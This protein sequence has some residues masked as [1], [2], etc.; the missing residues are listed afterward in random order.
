MGGQSRRGHDQPGHR[1]V[2][3]VRRRFHFIRIRRDDR[4]HLVDREAHQF[5]IELG[6]DVIATAE[7]LMRPV[8][9]SPISWPMSIAVRIWPRKLINPRTEDFDKGTGVIG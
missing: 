1:W 4:S 3:V 5:V 6:D 9:E 7:M 2:Q 8:A